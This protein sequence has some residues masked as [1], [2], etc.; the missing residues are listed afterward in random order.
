MPYPDDSFLSPT[1]RKPKK[2][3]VTI[4]AHLTRCDNCG[5]NVIT[6]RYLLHGQEVVEIFHN[7]PAKPEQLACK[8]A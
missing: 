2:K 1:H 3:H 6:S 7:D 5:G 4:S 8:K